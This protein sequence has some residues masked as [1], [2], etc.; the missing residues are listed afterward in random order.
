MQNTITN[1][2]MY[3]YTRGILMKIG[4]VHAWAELNKLCTEDVKFKA[5]VE[6]PYMQSAINDTELTNEL[7][8]C[9]C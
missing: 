9:G 3:V 5:W 1:G 4:T 7:K 2:K 6:A 8:K